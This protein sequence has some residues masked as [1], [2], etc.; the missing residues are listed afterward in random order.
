MLTLLV[1]GQTVLLGTVAWLFRKKCRELDGSIRAFVTPKGPNEASPLADTVDVGADMLAR[2][3]TAR[4]KTTFMG[5]I[6]GQVRQEKAV[7]G[8]IAEDVARAAHP[9]AGTILDAMPE[10]RK[11]LRKNPQLL[12]FALSKLV[13]IAD[14]RSEGIPRSTTSSTPNPNGRGING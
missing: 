13:G 4:L 12:D 10:L 14:K 2:A 3:V 6:S 1:L 9:L 8:A 5:Q 7:E 11:T